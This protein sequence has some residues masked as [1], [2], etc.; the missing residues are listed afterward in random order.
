MNR[1]RDRMVV[2]WLVQLLLVLVLLD[3][4]ERTVDVGVVAAAAAVVDWKIAVLSDGPVEPF[5]VYYHHR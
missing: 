2:C 5:A 3:D 1:R 4:E